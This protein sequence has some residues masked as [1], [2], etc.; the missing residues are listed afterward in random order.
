MRHRLF[1]SVFPLIFLHL[2]FYM[3]SVHPEFAYDKCSSGSGRNS[4]IRTEDPR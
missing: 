1:E 3:P 2:V 4:D